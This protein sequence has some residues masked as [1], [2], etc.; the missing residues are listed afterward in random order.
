MNNKQAE[1]REIQRYLENIE[2]YLKVAQLENSKVMSGGK[3]TKLRSYLQN[4]SKEC[5]T[6]RKS[7]LNKSKVVGKQPANKKKKEDD[8]LSNPLLNEQLNLPDEI[9]SEIDFPIKHEVNAVNTVNVVK[10]KAAP[11]RRYKTKKQLSQH[12]ISNF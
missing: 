5:S 11:Q 10:K 7:S 9:P 1:D 6:A 12:P 3:S 4:I 8:F 2:M